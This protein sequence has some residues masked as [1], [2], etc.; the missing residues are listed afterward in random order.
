LQADPFA[1]VPVIL[2]GESLAL[3]SSFFFKR[4]LLIIFIIIACSGL[5]AA[6]CACLVVG[7]FNA[8]QGEP[9]FNLL[10][11]G[12]VSEAW[13]NL[14]METPLAFISFLFQS[15]SASLPIEFRSGTAMALKPIALSHRF[16]LS[17]KAPTPPLPT[18]RRWTISFTQTRFIC[19]R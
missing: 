16:I 6:S 2:C 11:E 13:G 19:V 4:T 7:D 12:R 9:I 10:T 18:P 14:Q 3:F 8:T 5:Q 17:N 1:N 15:P